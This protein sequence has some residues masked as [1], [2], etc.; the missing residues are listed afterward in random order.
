MTDELTGDEREPEDALT[1]EAQMTV[2]AALLEDGRV[3]AAPV[4]V[5]YEGGTVRLQG[6]VETEEERRQAAEIAQRALPELNIVNEL[7]VW[8]PSPS[9]A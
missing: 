9:P 5:T 7:Q 1:V 6:F 8:R 2:K 3:A 4:R